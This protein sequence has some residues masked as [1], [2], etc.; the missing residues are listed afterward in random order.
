MTAFPVVTSF[1]LS[2]A[3]LALA[4]TPLYLSA[5]SAWAERSDHGL[6][7]DRLLGAAPRAAKEDALERLRDVRDE[8]DAGADGVG[9]DEHALHELDHAIEDLEQSLDPAFWLVDDEGNI[10]GAH[11]DPERGDHVFDLE[12]HTA[13]NV[14]DAIREGEIEN[15][16]LLDE[17]LA[18]VDTLVSVDRQLAE[19]A[20]QDAE[21]GGGDP[22]E[23]EEAREFLDEG[24]ALV[25]E[26]RST[27]DLTV[28]ASK[29]YEAVHGS[30]RHAWKAAT[31]A[32]DLD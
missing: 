1:R 11:L 10:D 4:G 12:R 7:G 15:E 27:S 8:I 25:E 29:L 9:D 17:L 6:D 24:D 13:H 31:D 2:A 5:P 30:Y 28:R 23:I 14:F 22:D 16:G 3:L 26:A 32:L 21:A 20:I 19:I 18:I